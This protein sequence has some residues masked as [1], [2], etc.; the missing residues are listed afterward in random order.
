M[1]KKHKLIIANIIIM[2]MLI[3][4]CTERGEGILKTEETNPD[5][6][7]QAEEDQSELYASP[8]AF[9]IG[10]EIVTDEESFIIK[11]TLDQ[12]F[13]GASQ[14][15][16]IEAQSGDQYVITENS[17][18]NEL[19][20]F[21]LI[22]RK[23]IFLPEYQ[24]IAMIHPLENPSESISFRIV[25]VVSIEHIVDVNRGYQTEIIGSERIHHFNFPEGEIEMKGTATE[26]PYIFATISQASYDLETIKFWPSNQDGVIDPV[27]KSEQVEY[28]EI[29]ADNVVELQT[30]P[31]LQGEIISGIKTDQHSVA[32]ISDQINSNDE[33]LDYEHISLLIFDCEFNLR[34][35]FNLADIFSYKDPLESINL[36]NIDEFEVKMII[37]TVE[38]NY[39][40]YFNYSTEESM[41]I[42]RSIDFERKFSI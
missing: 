17:T 37:R 39:D 4:A 34:D 41:T 11:N 7:L 19:N 25:D 14:Y 6:R 22:E 42:L 35:E 3:L 26:N 38:F 31:S 1:M 5:T 30:I 15:V 21:P 8:H 24:M 16:V 32:I 18:K 33:I 29:G 23:T 13:T 12:G 2:I 10:D 28:L 40:F 27:F 20:V 9:S 36:I